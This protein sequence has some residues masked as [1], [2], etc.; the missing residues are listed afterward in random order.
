MRDI[1]SVISKCDI[2]G[3]SMILLVHFVLST[4]VI[5]QLPVTPYFALVGLPGSGKSTLMSAS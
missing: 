5:E 1:Y 2:D 4:W 3:M